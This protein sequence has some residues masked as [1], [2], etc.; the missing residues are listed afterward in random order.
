MENQTEK[1]ITFFRFE[2][3]RIYHKALEYIDWVFAN[4]KNFPKDEAGDFILK[5]RNSAQAIAL[6]TAEGSARNKSQFVFYLKMAK[7]SVRECVVFTTIALNQNFFDQSLEEE[8]RKTLMELTKM[9]GAL[10][11]SLQR[12]NNYNNN[13]NSNN[14]N[15]NNSN[16][17]NN[18]NR[19]IKEI[20]YGNI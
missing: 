2:D 12:S 3:L 15:N 14:N 10:I 7:S 5:F 19:N 8:S 16:S 9:I 17:N 13:Y 18:Y 20:N 4:T 6:N 1:T 11:G